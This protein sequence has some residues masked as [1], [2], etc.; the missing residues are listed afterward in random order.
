MN[1]AHNDASTRAAD[2]LAAVRDQYGIAFTEVG[3]GGG[4]MALEARLESGHWIVA[5]DEGLYGFVD[6]IAGE[7]ADD[8]D[9]ESER[10]PYGWY[11]GIY[12]NNTEHGEDWW[13][14]GHEPVVDVTDYEAFADAL[15]ELVGRALAELANSR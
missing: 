10:Q 2:I 6:R 12:P 15:P 4:C 1:T 5:T 14:G 11:V 7:S 3:T 13:G 9:D 8:F